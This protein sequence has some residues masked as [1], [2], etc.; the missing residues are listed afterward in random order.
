MLAEYKRHAKEAKQTLAESR[1][2]E[3]RKGA[4]TGEDGTA[5]LT[6]TQVLDAAGQI[7]D[8]SKQ[9]SPCEPQSS[10]LHC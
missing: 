10:W 5:Q 3:L 9:A 8:K 1:K 4:S 7:Q 2:T 6:S